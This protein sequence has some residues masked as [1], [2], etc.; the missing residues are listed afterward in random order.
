[1]RAQTKRHPEELEKKITATAHTENVQ[2]NHSVAMKDL[3]SELP[4]K[5]QLHKAAHFGEKTLIRKSADYNT[6]NYANVWHSYF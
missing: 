3:S 5:L 6:R 4:L 2:K 1:M